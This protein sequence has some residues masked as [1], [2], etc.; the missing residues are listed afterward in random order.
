M[1]WELGFKCSSCG[2]TFGGVSVVENNFVCYAC[3]P[4]PEEEEEELGQQLD[5]ALKRERRW[6][7]RHEA[8]KAVIEAARHF[9]RNHDRV[10]NQCAICRALA[11]Y[12]AR[13]KP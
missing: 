12:D 11:A 3:K 13:S 2:K 9:V 1:S 10:G 4:R 6:I 7:E 5:A 8:A